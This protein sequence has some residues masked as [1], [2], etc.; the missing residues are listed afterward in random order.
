MNKEDHGVLRSVVKTNT[1]QDSLRLMRLSSV[2]DHI[3]GVDRVSVMMGTPANKQI[4]RNA[5]LA[6]TEVDAASATDL[7]VVADV[8]DAAT[9]DRVVAEVDEFLSSQA[10]AMSKSR[11]R[12]CRSLERAMS[13]AEKPGLAL[14]SIPG[15]YVAAEVDLLLDRGLH[16]LIFSDNVAIDDEVALKRRA[17]DLGLLVMGPDCGTGRIHGLPLAFSNAVHDGPIGLV[18]ASGTGLQEV[19]VQ[20][21]R[22]GGGVSQAIGLGS[23]DLSTQVGGITCL[24]ALQALEADADT[25]TIVIVSKPPAPEVRHEVLSVASSLSKPVVAILLGED[26]R[27]AVEGNVHYASTLE[28]AARLAVELAGP[29]ASRKVE[30][31]PEQRWL[32]AFYTG[33]TLAAEAAAL[34]GSQLGRPTDSRRADGCLFRSGGH[35]VIDFG[36][37]VF[38]R[39]RPHPM[40]D[41]TVRSVRLPAVFEDP[42]NAVLL[43]DVMLGYGSHPSPAE[44][45][46]EIVSREL[47]KLNAEGRDLAI[48]A[49]VCGTDDDPQH[50]GEQVRILEQAGVA[51]LP[52][53]AAAVRHGLAL[54]QRRRATPTT[55]VEAT[56]E[57]IRR[58]LAEPPSIINIGLRGF[59]ETLFDLGA[60]V[61]QYDWSPVAA[62]DRRLQAI[63]EGL[64]AKTST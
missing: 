24:Q 59:A 62:G 32:K 18:A 61:V 57:P 36:D 23:R 29:R 25:T 21:E 3:E 28:E 27:S 64:A 58:L 16:V 15:E 5:G 31:R 14:V 38:T 33:G 1:Y 46:A 9:G 55:R 52:S 53:N 60:D 63:L 42:E 12:S 10:F 48:V 2:L 13:I 4:L 35:E 54:L 17:R 22:L 44:A 41:P 30:L 34:L 56:P 49:S 6:T 7:I 47:A 50:M 43:L 39:G 40:I 8:F 37:D 45:I 51:V 20:I 26:P 11:L 19:M